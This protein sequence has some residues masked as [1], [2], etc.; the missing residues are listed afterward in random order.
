MRA[1]KL[2]I[3]VGHLPFRETLARWK[4]PTLKYRRAREDIIIII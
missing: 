1:T 4:L 2:V 3:A